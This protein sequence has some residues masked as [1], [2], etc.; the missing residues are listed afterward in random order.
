MIEKVAAFW[1]T[2]AIQAFPNIR[3]KTKW[4]VSAREREEERNEKKEGEET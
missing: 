3:N 2:N 1:R 4:R